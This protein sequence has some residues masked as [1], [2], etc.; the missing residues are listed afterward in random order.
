MSGSQGTETLDVLHGREHYGKEDLEPDPFGHE[1]KPTT[2]GQMKQVDCN[3]S[4]FK[5]VDAV[6][7]SKS[8]V[9]DMEAA[10]AIFGK[11][12]EHC[13]GGPLC[14][15]TMQYIKPADFL[16]GCP[17]VCWE[18]ATSALDS[19]DRAFMTEGTVYRRIADRYRKQQ[20]VDPVW[21]DKTDLWE[22]QWS[23]SCPVWCHEGRHRAKVA[24]NEG[25]ALIPAIVI[26]PDMEAREVYRQK[27]RIAK[28]RFG[29]GEAP[30][31]PL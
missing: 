25:I 23:E 27:C 15:V 19:P 11:K 28:R 2:K 18:G 12:M 14:K 10:M 29:L 8:F 13:I 1:W 21:L 3:E 4:I 22:K 6:Q 26:E 16:K 9:P 20:E 17:P 24:M 5:Y 30:T 31:S 7:D